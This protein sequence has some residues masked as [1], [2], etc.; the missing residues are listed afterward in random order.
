MIERENDPLR[1]SVLYKLILARTCWRTKNCKF[2]ITLCLQGYYSCFSPKILSCVQSF[3]KDSW[4]VSPLSAE[5]QPFL[6]MVAWRSWTH[7][8]YFL[9]VCGSLFVMDANVSGQIPSWVNYQHPRAGR[10]PSYVSFC[11]RLSGLLL[12]LRPCSISVKKTWKLFSDFFF[13]YNL[14]RQMAR[15][16]IWIIFSCSLNKYRGISVGRGF[17]T[18]LSFTLIIQPGRFY[19][20]PY[21]QTDQ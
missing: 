8:Y 5:G 9:V 3:L 12:A 20:F 17:L 15:W 13:L 7:S 16:I 2:L 1:Y 21:Q 14:V 4:N 6:L 19:V 18:Q 11:P 10:G